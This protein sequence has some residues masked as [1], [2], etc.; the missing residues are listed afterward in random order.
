MSDA[1]PRIDSRMIVSLAAPLLEFVDAI[2]RS[3]GREE[4]Y[5]SLPLMGGVAAARSDAVFKLWRSRRQFKELSDEGLQA[6]LEQLLID[7]LNYPERIHALTEAAII[8]FA[9]PKAADVI[10]PLYGIDLREVSLVLA[11]DVRA[12]FVTDEMYDEVIAQRYLATATTSGLAWAKNPKR[13][14]R[15]IADSVRRVVAGRTVL[16][17]RADGEERVALWKA[18]KRADLAVDALQYLFARAVGDRYRVFI[19]WRLDAPPMAWR[20]TAIIPVEGD[21]WPLNPG[22]RVG[23]LTPWCPRDEELKFLHELDIF[24]LAMLPLKTDPT[25]LEDMVA[26]AIRAFSSGERQRT[27]DDRKMAYVSVFDI[28]FSVKGA[29]ETT[30]QIREGV[31]FAM[32]KDDESRDE[33][34]FDMAKFINAV[35]ASRSFTTHEFQL[36]LFEPKALTRLREIARRL[37]DVMWRKYAFTDKASIQAWLDERRTALGPERYARYDDLS[38]GSDDVQ[39]CSDDAAGEGGDR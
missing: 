11:P 9:A 16:D 18:E 24:R 28:F 31:A 34:R 26:R 33:V 35:Y 6:R 38:R 4:R 20:H 7:V 39:G 2:F 25:P 10:L 14:A 37:I 3:Y 21:V 12:F 5:E 32:H 36:G 23:T 22:E 29:D 19:D 15:D 30:R 1:K 17:I 13:T 27:V 8:R